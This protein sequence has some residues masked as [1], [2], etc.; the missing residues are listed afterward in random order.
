MT[1]RYGTVTAG[2]AAHGTYQCTAVSLD[3][4][5]ENY[6]HRSVRSL[7]EEIKERQGDPGYNCHGLA[8]IELIMIIGELSGLATN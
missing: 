5:I 1:R 3:I 8:K 2:I 7:T 6:W 4:L